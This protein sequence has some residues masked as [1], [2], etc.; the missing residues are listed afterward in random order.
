MT[1]SIILWGSLNLFAHL[2]G[3]FPDNNYAIVADYPFG[4][5]FSNMSTL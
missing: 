5:L 2:V 1:G 3:Q 4:L